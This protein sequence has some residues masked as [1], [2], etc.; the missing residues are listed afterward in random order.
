M[1]P[2]LLTTHHCVA[3]NVS[4]LAMIALLVND[5]GDWT[6]V[7]MD[8]TVG[9]SVLHCCRSLHP[10]SSSSGNSDILS[11]NARWGFE[12]M[13]IHAGSS[14]MVSAVECRWGWEVSNG[15]TT[16]WPRH[17]ALIALSELVVM[18]VSGVSTMALKREEVVVAIQPC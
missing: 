8:P 6:L 3:E 11:V 14:L 17:L 18:D 12:R 9:W 10:I 16:G 1:S 2:S 15:E 7:G 5:L 13:A 4:S